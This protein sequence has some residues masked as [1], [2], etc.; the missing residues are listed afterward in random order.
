MKYLHTLALYLLVCNSAF[1]QVNLTDSA[2]KMNA[3]KQATI[4]A[5]LLLK[6]DYV[7]F[8]AYTYDPIIK[9]IGGSEKMAKLLQES[10]EKMEQDDFILSNVTAS[11]C[12]NIVRAETQLQCTL[13]E[14]LE[15]KYKTGKLIQKST[16]IDISSDKG[17]S[18]TFID[19]HGA[20][21]EELQ[22]TL[23]ELSSNLIIP[24]QPKPEMIPN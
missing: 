15:I 7:A 22:K 10:F 3:E 19:T 6:K 1:S 13:T 11:N 9:M 14:T 24:K 5:N 12:S 20:T 21:L 18:W 4:M 2:S 16:I 17:V 8:A 23:K